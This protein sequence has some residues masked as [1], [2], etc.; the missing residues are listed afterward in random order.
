[1]TYKEIYEMG[2]ASL[3]QA[4]VE[5]AALD[6]RILLEFVCGTNRNDLFAHGEKPVAYEKKE[7]YV[8]YIN[9]R[10]GHIPLQHITGSQDFMGLSFQVNEKVL[11][12]RQDTELLVEEVMLYLH[13]GM[14]ILDVCTGSG[15]ILLSLLHYSNDC[16]GIGVDIS[17]EALLVAQQN[18]RNLKLEAEFLESDLFAV[19]EPD[20]AAGKLE[21]FDIIVS[22]P[23][24]IETEVVETLAEE[25]KDH[26]PV[27][28]LDGGKDGLDFYRKIA[29]EAGG[30]LTRGGMLF[31]EIGYNQGEAV[32]K[33]L[34]ECGFRD[35]QLKKDYAGLDRVVFGTFLE[36]KHV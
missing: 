25:V 27:I 6:A 34:R 14:S 12:P 23:P 10:A 15:C 22:N 17:K 13:D 26:E 19:F 32:T 18:C 16:R 24:Y 3:E 30:Y 5:E 2:K 20:K 33:L 4:G 35:V 29:K 21:K 8:N 1:M 31:L 28:A 36:E 7:T 9:R 11:I